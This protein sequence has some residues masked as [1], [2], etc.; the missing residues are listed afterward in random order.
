MSQNPS[1]KAVGGLIVALVV[2]F[3]L[4]AFGRN[5]FV[6]VPAGHVAVATLFGK[7]SDAQYP[8]GLHFPVN[9]LQKF[10]FYDVRQDERKEE[11]VGIPT[12]D[13]LITEVDVSVKFRLD[14]SAVAKM[15][16]ET[17]DS[18]RVINV[19][20][21]PILRSVLREQ[22]KTIKSAQDFFLPETQNKLQTNI[23]S[24]L[25]AQLQG[26]GVLVEA[27]LLRD[28]NLPASVKAIVE[29]KVQTEQEV[30]RQKAELERQKI[31]LQK[32]VEQA[33]ASRTAAEEEAQKRRTLA[34]AQ[35]YE[36]QK[37]NEAI[38]TN[39]AYIKL[40]ALKALQAISKDPAAKVYFMNGDSPMPLPL[41]MM[42]ETET[43]K[44]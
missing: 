35:A 37:I 20:L 44:K 2:M 30:E 25:Q 32:E 12:Q 39:P 16:S 29:R 21:L 19:H 40:E 5:L 27:V 14:R 13:Q 18:Q 34:D 42:G 17:G 8:E 11:D 38:S 41:M 22:G 1:P 43:P 3:L 9:P 24:E 31:E 6:T 10:T 15:L 26:K 28:I 23:L 36:I 4:V 7:V 33:K